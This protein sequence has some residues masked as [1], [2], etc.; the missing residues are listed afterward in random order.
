MEPLCWGCLSAVGGTMAS[1]LDFGILRGVEFDW[2]VE[3][4]ID[5]QFWIGIDSQV[6]TYFGLLDYSSLKDLLL[7]K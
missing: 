6:L 3:I 7:R 2:Q 5:S 1:S 4:G